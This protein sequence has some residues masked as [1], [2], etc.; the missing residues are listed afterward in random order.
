M[1]SSRG[2]LYAQLNSL[3]LDVVFL[4]GEGNDLFLGKVGALTK[5]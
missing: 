4:T 2:R 3:H 1:K 5:V